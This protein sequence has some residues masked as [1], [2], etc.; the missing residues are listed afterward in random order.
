MRS[1]VVA[2]EYPWPEDSGARLRLAMILR[3]LRRC[4][5]TELFSVV[6]KFRTD[7]DPPDEDLGLA[8]VGRVGF[9][10]RTDSAGHM[11]STALRPSVP[12]GMP[13]RDRTLVQRALASFVSGTYDLIWFYGMRPWVLAGGLTSSPT[14]LDLID[15]EDQKLL[16]RLSVPQPPAPDAVAR[17]R[18]AGARLVSE[19]EV[20][21]WQRLHRRAGRRV[22]AVVVCSRLDADRARAGHLALVN[23]LPNGYRAVADPVGR[24]A[25]GSPPVVLFQGLLR[26]PPN[27]EAARFLGG[28]IAPALRAL[29]PDAQIRLV[30][31][32]DPALVSLHDPPSVTVVGRVPDIA[33]ELAGADLVVV[34]V[35][36]GSGTR[37]KI[38]EAF[39]HRIPVVSTSL[40]AEGL[41]A[42]DG[43][44]LLLGESASELAAACARVLRDESLRASI[45]DN[46]HALFSDRFRSEVIE[47]EVARLARNV[48]SRI[49]R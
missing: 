3:G 29:V 39:A 23:V 17:L 12:L 22:S 6:S 15:L 35:H 38:L 10:N 36:Y 46:A 20:R 32:H 27:A 25:V 14:I 47:A 2:G 19:E 37:L 40:G 49:K 43:V 31:A 4:G 1:L 5:P 9:D 18:R 28:D 24:V 44:H 42:R 7:F 45:T 21:R 41:D 13:W 26:Y 8:K 11:I 16:A 30:G 33:V 34:P 48:A